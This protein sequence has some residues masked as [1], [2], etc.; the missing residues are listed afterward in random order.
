MQ[1]GGGKGS[2]YNP[3]DRSSPRPPDRRESIAAS[4]LWPAG[5]RNPAKQE[6]LA[7]QL[8]IHPDTIT[9]IKRDERFRKMLEKRADGLNLDPE[10]IQAVINA[11]YAKACAGD[12][13]AASLYLEYVK[14]FQPS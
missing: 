2:T 14:Q 9:R 13:K 6:G 4:L 8:G 5:L 3:H 11:M 1:N 7:A 10:R 12:T